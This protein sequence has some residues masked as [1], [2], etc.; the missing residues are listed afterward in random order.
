MEALAL[1][2]EAVN[3][4]EN[5][6][7]SKVRYVIQFTKFISQ[8]DSLEKES[9]DNASKKRLPLGFLKGKAKVRFSDDWEMTEEE[10]LGL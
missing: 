4:I 7:D 2:S 9:Q 5:L 8:Q 10:L 6:P 1:K 3:L